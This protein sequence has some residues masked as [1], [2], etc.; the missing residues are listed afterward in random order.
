MPSLDTLK[1]GLDFA[2]QWIIKNYWEPEMESFSKDFSADHHPIKSST[3]YNKLHKLLDCYG[4][5][6]I[7]SIWGTKDIGQ[8]TEQEE[9]YEHIKELWAVFQIQKDSKGKKKSSTN[10][11][12]LHLK[13]ALSIIRSEFVNYVSSSSQEFKREFLYKVRGAGF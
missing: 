11:D 1:M 7:Y 4:Y 3:E 6:K 13:D 10:I 9:L 5:L 2:I 8:L 12:Q